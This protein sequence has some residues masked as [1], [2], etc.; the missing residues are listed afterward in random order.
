MT[1]PNL[2]KFIVVSEKTP[3]LKGANKH[4]IREITS[5]VEEHKKSISESPSESQSSQSSASTKS[6]HEVELLNKILV[7]EQQVIEIINTTNELDCTCCLNLRNCFSGN[8]TKVKT[9]AV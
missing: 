8:K 4:V 7:V 6:E 1:E 5:H 3:V 2:K 9:S